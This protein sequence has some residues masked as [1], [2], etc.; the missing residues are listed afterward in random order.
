MNP[1]YDPKIIKNAIYPKWYRLFLW[2][3]PTYVHLGQ[4]INTYYKVIGT[5]LFVVKMESAPW[6]RNFLT[7]SP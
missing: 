1:F 5:S 2:M 7:P 6:G 3:F 4:E